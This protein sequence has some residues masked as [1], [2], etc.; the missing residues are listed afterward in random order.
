MRTYDYI[1]VGSGSAGAVVAGRLSEDPSTRVLLI[2]AG[3]AKKPM[4]VKV[5]AAFP[6][7]FKTDLD[8]EVY[9]EPEPHLDGRVIYH[10]RAKLLG[11]CSAM[12]AMMY[13]RGSRHDYDSWAKGG[14]TGWSYDEVLPLFKR[15]ERNSRGASEYHGDAGPLHIEDPRTPT[16]LTET[17]I[18]AMCATGLSRNDDFNGA[19]QLGAGYNQL[20]QKRGMRWTTADGFVTPATKRANFTLL[21]GAHVHRVRVANGRAVGVEVEVNGKVEFYAADREVV[22][23]AGAFNTPQLLMLSGIGPADHLAEHGIASVV[24][25]PNVGAHLMDHPL[26][27][28]N[29]ETTARGTLAGAESPVQLVKY[30]A[31]RRGMLT[32]NIG[33]AGAFFHTRSGEDAPDVQMFGAPAY[34]WDNGFAT[35]DKPAFA[36]ALSLVGST[37]RGHLR[38]RSADPKAQIGATFNYFAER[39]D[40]DSMVAGIERAREAAAYGPLRALTTKEIHPGAAVQTR[41][42]I[43]AE[44]R[45]N[46]SHTFHPACTARIGTEVD[47]VVDPDLRVHGVVGLR[48]ADAS[49]FPTIPHGNTHAPTVLVGEKAADLIRATS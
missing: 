46:V 39:A 36:F 44:I 21:S 23:S 12:N 5:P 7:Q 6:T 32:S 4:R 48:V 45:R 1:V 17:L 11:G 30:L 14:A 18:E 19:D 28:T 37:S 34:F 27:L 40:M 24:D 9:T 15:S 49:V 47:G 10:P 13:I 25:N 31:A 33:E 3:G 29:H 42:E 8:W 43:E 2:E 38:L 20:T 41:Q 22:L 26:Y 35:H 16:P